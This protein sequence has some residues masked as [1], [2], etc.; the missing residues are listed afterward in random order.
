MVMRFWLRTA[1]RKAQKCGVPDGL[2]FKMEPEIGLEMLGRVVEHG[3]VPFA[4]VNADEH[5]GVSP[6]FLDDVGALEPAMW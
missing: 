3:A 1:R 6:D 4:W 5:Y 2:V